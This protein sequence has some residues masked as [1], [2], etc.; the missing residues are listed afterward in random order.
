MVVISAHWPDAR[1][2]PRPWRRQSPALAPDGS[3]SMLRKPPVRLPQISNTPTDAQAA[4]PPRAGS[5]GRRRHSR[6]PPEMPSRRRPAR[7]RPQGAPA[8]ASWPLG[9]LRWVGEGAWCHRSPPR[10]A[11]VLRPQPGAGSS[12]SRASDHAGLDHGGAQAGEVAVD[13]VRQTP[14]RSAAP[15]S[16]CSSPAPRP[17]PC[18]RGLDDHVG[19]RLRCASLMP[20]GAVDTAPVADDHVDALLLQRGHVDALDARASEV[21]PMAFILPLSMYCWNSL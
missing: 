2:T 16:S 12:L 1:P 6:R 15:A 19:Q 7:R 5:S 8:P 14:C 9:A 13:E 20:A 11:G 18:S 17:R 3:G 10:K 4:A 21:T